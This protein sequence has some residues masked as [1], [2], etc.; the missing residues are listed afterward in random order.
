LGRQGILLL[1]RL[2]QRLAGSRQTAFFSLVVGNISCQTRFERQQ[3]RLLA[4]RLPV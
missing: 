1:I 2:L 3:G 4:S